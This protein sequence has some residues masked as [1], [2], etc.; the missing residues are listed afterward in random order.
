M[1]LQLLLLGGVAWL[2]RSWLRRSRGREVAETDDVAPDAS[3]L[4]PVSVVLGVMGAMALVVV[5]PSLSVEYGVLRAFMQTMLVV[6]PV[7]AIGLWWALRLVRRPGWLAGVTIALFAVLT[8]TA[9]ALVGGGP[10]KLALADAGVY[11]ERYIVEDSDEAA[12]DHLAQAPDS[13]K[14]LPKVLA[15]TNQTARLALAGVSIDEVDGRTFPTALNVGSYFFADSRITGDR[16]DTLFLDGDRVTYR[17]PLGRVE[18]RLDLVYSAGQ[19]R[20][21]R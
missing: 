3:A 5:V 11:H 17:Y 20:V 8:S 16:K 9:T 12:I 13:S 6:A 21:Y 19:S 1:L 7:A 10:P 18:D 14:E 15:P 2:V 4:E